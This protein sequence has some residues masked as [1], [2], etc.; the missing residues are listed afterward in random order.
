DAMRVLGNPFAS[1]A[2]TLGF[3]ETRDKMESAGFDYRKLNYIVR[4]EDD[5]PRPIS[6]DRINKL[7]LVKG[8]FDGLNAIEAAHKDLSETDRPDSEQLRV[9]ATLLFDAA[10]VED[11]VA[12][13]EG[14]TA[15]NADTTKN[16]AVVSEQL[17]L[18]KKLQGA[19]PTDVL[20]SLGRK[21][22]YDAANG[23]LTAIGLLS[24]ME[25]AKL[26]EWS[27]QENWLKS[28]AILEKR[29]KRGFDKTLGA[30]IESEK[31]VPGANQDAIRDIETELRRS[32]IVVPIPDDP[33]EDA[34][35]RPLKTRKFFELYLPYLRR[36]LAQRLILDT[37]SGYARLDRD[38]TNV[39]ISTVLKAGGRSLYDVF[40][41]IKTLAIPAGNAWTG[42]LIP[43]ADAD[44]SFFVEGKENKPVIEG[45]SIKFEPEEESLYSWQSK[46][47]SLKAG[48]LYLVTLTNIAPQD[49]QWKTA[50]TKQAVVP[51]IHWLPDFAGNDVENALGILHRTASLTAGFNLS[52]DEVQYL[53][54]HAPDFGDLNFS[55]PSLNHLLRLE[56]Y[57]RLRNSLPKT[58]T[59]LLEFFDWASNTSDSSELAAKISALTRWKQERVEKLISAKNYKLLDADHFR[60]EEQLLRLHKAIEVAD[61]IGMD[62][63]LLFEW[64]RT[65]S[66][67]KRALEIAESIRNA[68]R[69]RYRQEDWEQV[70]K[71]LH[72]K[73]RANQ[74]N[75]LVAWILQRPELIIWGVTDADG[76][77]EYFLI[78]VQMEPCMETS[79][80]KQ[81]ISSVQLF[82]QR[83]FLGL[84]EKDDNSGI[85]P[86]KLDRNRWNWMQRYRVWEANRKVFLYPENWIEPNLRDDKSPFFKELESELLQK[87]IN[88]QNVTD[89]LKNYLYKVDE[90]ANM[91]VVGLYVDGEKNTEGRWNESSKLHVFSRTRNA[92]YVFY[93]R[94]LALD[95]MNWY[96]W[97]KMQVD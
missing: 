75:A 18:A 7:R 47:I 96:P 92:P 72:D 48:K 58:G 3:M 54:D 60:N 34:N 16:L 50:T 65:S 52:A 11:I 27:S 35:T 17:A 80:I 2:A 4:G 56:A 93:Y 83:C 22:R 33:A 61:K 76:L 79:R 86:E 59:N 23:K 20:A 64:A 88:K 90:V 24:D 46:S 9:K 13:V 71:P 15:C 32:D 30:I 55:S 73:L 5:S 42:Y 14:A 66:T 10:T 91:E 74:R 62:I 39:L 68:I 49:L 45:L 85:G 87:D 63:D 69:A 43:P 89:A 6:P 29:Q 81:A 41:S 78:D 57:T 38:T 44:Y 70:A 31:A 37:L 19:A 40:E 82:I 25:I 21:I 94:Y 77:F 53:Y 28:V 36:K 1:P 8:L 12:I 67:F 84:E 26:K 97:E 95:E 51:A